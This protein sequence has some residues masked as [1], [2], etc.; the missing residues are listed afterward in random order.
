MKAV[1]LARVADDAPTGPLGLAHR[2]HDP[3]TATTVRRRG[4]EL[5]LTDGP[6]DESADP[7]VSLEE[8]EVDGFDEAVQRAARLPAAEEG[9]VEVRRIQEDPHHDA[10]PATPRPGTR[11]YL[12]LHVLPAGSAGTVVAGTRL[13]D[14]GPTT[15]AIVRV[16]NGEMQ[17]G[18]G[19]PDPHAEEIAGYDIIA[20]RDLD[21]AIEVAR[22][23][24][25]LA[26]GAIEIRPLAPA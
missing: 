22:P 26:A 15:A 4:A 13:A 20:V 7:I 16:R 14:A 1:L 18:H 5:L 10:A 6:C 24:P 8:I 12:F 3:S 2:L 17:V 9:A 23:H 25:T 19:W 21:D 11:R